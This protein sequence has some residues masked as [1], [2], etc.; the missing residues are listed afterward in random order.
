MVEGYTIRGF[1]GSD[2]D[3]FLELYETTFGGSHSEEW[4]DWKY[5]APPYVDH[6]PIVVSE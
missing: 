6:V 4:F 3:E 5:R 2:V 1:R